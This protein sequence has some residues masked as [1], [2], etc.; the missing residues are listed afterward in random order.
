MT[1]QFT[2]PMIKWVG[3]K[4]Q[5]LE[6]IMER[7]P[8][9]MVNYHEP[10]LGGGS[11]LLGLLTEVKRGSIEL[12]GEVYAY[13]ANEA[14]IYVY[15]NIQTKYI[16]LYNDLQVLIGEY[17]QSNGETV[18]R[19]PTN[20]EEAKQS[21]EN[22]YY[23]TRSRYNNLSHDERI[24]TLGSAMFIFMNKTCFRGVFRVGP[25][26][27]NVPFGNN[28]NPEIINRKH[29]EEV[30]QLIQGVHF[31]FCDF[32]KSIIRVN[33]GDFVYMDPPY[34]PEKETSFVGYTE[35]GFDSEKHKELF[36]LCHSLA[37][38]G[39]CWMMSNS[40]VP[41]VREYFS[42]EKYTVEGI[43]CKRSI[44]SKNPDTKAKEVI[45]CTRP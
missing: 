9:K 28:R 44:H 6:C 25:N 11:V 2:K 7:F 42:S 10:F 12:S 8:R 13:D 40:D 16:E 37:D 14:L 32:S 15:K 21:K 23:W 18:N 22:Y 20:L 4:T 39:I 31:E 41:L 17:N 34:A 33:P 5:I 26:G 30:H 38:R 24:S 36:K 27:F 1:A 45:I 35:N 3:G 43:L 29:L 19:K